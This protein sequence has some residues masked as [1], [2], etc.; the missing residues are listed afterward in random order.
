M[1]R[2]DLVMQP[3]A[4]FPRHRHAQELLTLLESGAV[5]PAD[6]GEITITEED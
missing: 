5:R 2:D 3:G 4:R 6:P 1:R